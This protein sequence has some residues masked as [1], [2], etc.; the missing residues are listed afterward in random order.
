MEKVL[1]RGM[2]SSIVIIGTLDTKGDKVAYLKHLIEKEAETIIIDCGILGKPL[3][4][5][6]IPREE[7]AEVAG[8]SLGEIASLG[9]ET[10]AMR[11]MTNGTSKIVASETGWLDRWLVEI[12]RLVLRRFPL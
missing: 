11:I 3:C 9:D 2:A 8:K 7:V 4:Q 12:T 1:E 5:A 10:Q 6:D